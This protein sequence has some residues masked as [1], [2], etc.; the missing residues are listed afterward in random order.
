MAKLLEGRH[1]I[2][3]AKQSICK[4]RIFTFSVTVSTKENTRISQRVVVMVC[5]I[6]GRA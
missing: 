4:D 5:S 2:G 3:M 6:E 1:R